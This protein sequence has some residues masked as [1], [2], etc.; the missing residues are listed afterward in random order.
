MRHEA[1]SKQCI[2]LVAEQ[3]KC[4][5]HRVHVVRAEDEAENETDVAL[6]ARQGLQQLPLAV[7]CQSV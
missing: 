5:L 6:V 3:V 2:H 1:N 4:D 7:D